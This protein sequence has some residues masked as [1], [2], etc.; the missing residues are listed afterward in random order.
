MMIKRLLEAILQG[1]HVAQARL[2][3]RPSQGAAVATIDPVRRGVVLLDLFPVAPVSV[4]V[5][6]VDQDVC[7][8][9]VVAKTPKNRQCGL[10]TIPCFLQ[11]S[12]AQMEDADVGPQR[13]SEFPVIRTRCQLQSPIE[14]LFGLS[15]VGNIEQGVAPVK[16]G[17]QRGP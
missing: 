10:Q 17:R 4:N 14:Y 13:S 12:L 8:G 2:H 1:V 3:V 9:T 11:L 5:A 6:D 7:L 16:E 15:V